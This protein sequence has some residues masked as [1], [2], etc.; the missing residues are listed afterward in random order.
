M[1]RLKTTEDKG[2]E[3]A[4]FGARGRRGRDAAEKYYHWETEAEKLVALYKKLLSG[5]K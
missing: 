2:S 3:T 1:G 4:S 5:R